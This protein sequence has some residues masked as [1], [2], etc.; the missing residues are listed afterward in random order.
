MPRGGDHPRPPTPQK[1][2]GWAGAHRLNVE[3]PMVPWYNRDIAQTGSGGNSMGHIQGVDPRQ[4]RLICIDDMVRPD[5]EARFIAGFVDSLDMEGLGFLNAVADG[6][7]RPPYDPAAMAKLLIFSYGRAVRSSRKIEELAGDSMQAMWLM[8]GL[9]PDFKTIADFRRLNIGPLT[10]LMAEYC[11]FADQCGLFGKR[12]AAVDGTKIKADSNRKNQYSRK[13]LE[14][15]VERYRGQI[16]E[17]MSA[18][19]E[20]DGDA[21]DGGADAEA[22]RIEDIKARMERAKG[23]LAAMDESGEGETSPVDPD[24]RL[25]AGGTGVGKGVDTAY[26]LQISVDAK[27]HLVPAFDVVQSPSDQGQLAHMAGLTQEALGAGAITVLADKGYYS[28]DDIEACEALGATP[29]VARQ[30][31]PGEGGGG[32]YS[33]DRFRHD[34]ERDACLCP[35][36][37]WL[38]SHSAK[39]TKV[40]QFFD[41]GACKGCPAKGECAGK[42][43]Y[44]RVRRSSKNGVLDRADA[45]YEANKELYRLRQQTVEH[46]FGTVKRA[47]GGGYFL[48]RTKRKV[49][50][51]AA[52]MLLCYNIKR[53]RACLGPEKAMEMLEGWRG[54][55]PNGLFWLAWMRISA[56]FAGTAAA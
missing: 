23:W 1:V 56:F 11:S 54:S 26:N 12:V 22:G 36:G 15:D 43:G 55:L 35:E 17:Y 41:K 33:L 42:D 29:I 25:M 46:V 13:R 6:R 30:R 2:G 16:Q 14:R 31:K 19:E 52:L 20:S 49:K 50:A 48:L 38:P 3:I 28:A 34:A 21:D 18:L 7:G 53:T 32:G 8:G 5:C 37:H 27:E 40:R 9:T 39:G 24:A 51:E 10:G 47:L 44:R 45:R 4:M